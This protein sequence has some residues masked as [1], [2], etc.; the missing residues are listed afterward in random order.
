[1]RYNPLPYRGL[2]RGVGVGRESTTYSLLLARSRNLKN[3]CN[4][5]FKIE[6]HG[7]MFCCKLIHKTDMKFQNICETKH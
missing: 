6:P 3:I 2:G 1:M 7:H 4:V 5:F